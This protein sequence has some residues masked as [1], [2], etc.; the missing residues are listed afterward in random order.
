MSWCGEVAVQDSVSGNGG[1]STSH[2]TCVDSIIHTLGK[3]VT[4]SDNKLM[5]C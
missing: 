1:G 2:I 4:R 3:P 5:I